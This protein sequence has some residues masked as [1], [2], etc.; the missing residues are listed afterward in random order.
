M[1]TEELP[2]DFERVLCV[3]AHPDDLEYGSAGAVARWRAQG[4]TVTYLLATAGEAGIDTME[5][6]QAGPLRAQEERDGAREVGVDVVEFLG[7]PDGGLSYGQELRAGIAGAIRKHRP[8][9]VLTLTHREQF[10]GGGV[11]QADHRIVGLAAL[12]ACADAGN[13][14]LHPEQLGEDLQPW[15]GVQL[16]AFASSPVATH[17]V[18]VTDHIDAAVRSLA[19]HAQYL[20]ALGPDYPSPSD[21]LTQILQVP[22]AGDGDEAN[23]PRFALR[24]EVFR[25]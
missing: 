15:G 6:A 11:N 23:Q 24:L 10:A 12:D 14:W 22:A 8:D 25:L 7:L 2:E 4:K 19:A 17:H 20:Q 16:V 18:D 21:L 1:E 9:V 13:R 3:A 5:P